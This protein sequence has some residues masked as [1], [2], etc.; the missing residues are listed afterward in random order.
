MPS[1]CKSHAGFIEDETKPTNPGQENDEPSTA[2]TIGI[3]IEIPTAP[4][5]LT[6]TDPSETV[7][8]N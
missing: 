4:V 8:A 6:T 2:P 7:A 1:L 5:E 3:E